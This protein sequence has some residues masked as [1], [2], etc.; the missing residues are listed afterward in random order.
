VITKYGANILTVV[1]IGGVALL[2]V[3]GVHTDQVP[4]CLPHFPTLIAVHQLPLPVD[5]VVDHAILPV[6]LKTFFTQNTQPVT[7]IL[8]HFISD[9]LWR[10][11]D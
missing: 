1:P 6:H 4:S 3:E 10:V 11:Y 2:H 9:V 7:T 8:R 5:L